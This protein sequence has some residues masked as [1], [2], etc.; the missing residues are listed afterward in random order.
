MYKATRMRQNSV[1][2]NKVGHV[3]VN[4]Y[5]TKQSIDVSQILDF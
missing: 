4:I 1:G 2:D 5:G 3:Y